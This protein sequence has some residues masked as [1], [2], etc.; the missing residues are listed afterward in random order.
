MEQ[1]IEKEYEDEFKAEYE[2]E[3]KGALKEGKLDHAPLTEEVW[4]C[5]SWL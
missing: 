1:E 3:L 4:F 5:I 2:D